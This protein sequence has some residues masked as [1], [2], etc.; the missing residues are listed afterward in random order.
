MMTSTWP[1]HKEYI[2][3]QI[4]QVRVIRMINEFGKHFAKMAVTFSRDQWVNLSSMLTHWGQVTHICVSKLSIIGSDN[5]LSRGQRQA[6][7]WTNTGILL[8]G[9]LR[10]NFSEISNGIQ[11]FAFMKM[12][13][14]MS[15]GKCRPF[16]LGLNVLRHKLIPGRDSSNALS[17]YR[18][19]SL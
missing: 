13:L 2:P 5:G 16:W 9:P 17:E 7:I 6:S 18:Q 8:I 11:T 1:D 15:Y 10:T 3:M 14:K 4:P 19:C 12:C